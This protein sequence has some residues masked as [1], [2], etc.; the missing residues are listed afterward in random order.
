MTGRERCAK[1]EAAGEIPRLEDGAAVQPWQVPKRKRRAPEPAAALP[2]LEIPPLRI[3]GG[4]LLGIGAL[5]IVLALSMD[6]T[7]ATGYAGVER[8]NNV[9]LMNDRLVYLSA[10]GIAA[11]IGAILVV[12]TLKRP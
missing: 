3:A 8:V 9:G 7:V 10:G 11:I 2:S 6:T 1:C 5:A 4:A 12:A